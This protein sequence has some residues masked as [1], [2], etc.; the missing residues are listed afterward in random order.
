M[1]RET[2]VLPVSDVELRTVK[3][4][5]GEE[6]HHLTFTA[7]PFDEWSVD[8][9]GFKERIDPKAFAESSEDVI[10]TFEHRNDL[11]LGRES[12]GTLTRKESKAGYEWDVL[13][14]P[15]TNAGRDAMA[16]AKR[17]DVKGASFEFSVLGDEWNEELSERTVTKGI[18]Y[19]A[20]PVV[21]P[22][23]EMN[24]VTV[25]QRSRDAAL[26]ERQARHP[27]DVLTVAEAREQLAR[28]GVML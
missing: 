20:G 17:G 16:H 24:D 25:A 1:K 7:P 26:A 14:N 13:L 5:D 15:D 18:L 3:R 22:A 8:L 28:A 21:N 23:Y 10:A 11:L 6:E 27:V 2:R 9:G 19:Q 12:S 4:D